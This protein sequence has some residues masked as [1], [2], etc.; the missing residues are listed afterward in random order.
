MRPAAIA[1]LAACL[2]V[3][4]VPTR[5]DQPL[6]RPTRDVDVTYRASG[7]ALPQD[8]R[9]LEQRVRWLAAAQTTRID[10]PT[11]GL[12]VIID[13]VARHMSVVREANRSVIEMA[14]PEDMP[15]VAAKPGIGGYVR[16][17]DDSVAGL[18]CTEWETRD[19]D[20]QPALVCITADGVLLR[21]R[22]QG[23]LLVSAVSVRYGPQDPAAFRVPADYTHRSAGAAK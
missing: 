7:A 10:P 18:P 17:N 12:F 9:R 16:R 1:I 4:A 19:R 14:A 22:A 20:G 13:Y 15:G 23:R 6:L 11:T 21:A 8:P 2:A 3:M 5:A